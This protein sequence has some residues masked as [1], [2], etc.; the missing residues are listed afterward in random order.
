MHPK[1]YDGIKTFIKF[2]GAE[3]SRAASAA[4]KH[5]SSLE[6]KTEVCQNSTTT[7]LG[8]MLSTTYYGLCIAWHGEVQDLCKK[9]NVPFREAMSRFNETYNEGYSVLGKNNVIRPV[10]YPPNSKIGGHCVIPNAE[11]LENIL[12]SLAIDLIL[13]Y[14]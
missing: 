9:Y 2:I 7:E 3:S 4:D 11:L 14:S 13:K 8:K 12:S 6:I 10:L 1:L 5:L